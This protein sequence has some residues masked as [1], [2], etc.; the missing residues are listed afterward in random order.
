MAFK[1][2]YLYFHFYLFTKHLVHPFI[3]YWFLLIFYLLCLTWGPNCKTLCM[4]FDILNE[5]YF[6]GVELLF[7]K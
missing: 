4:M 1:Y 2:S 7:G 5:D 6:G 3:S